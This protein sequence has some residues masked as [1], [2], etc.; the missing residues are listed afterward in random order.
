MIHKNNLFDNNL[1]YISNIKDGNLSYK[2]NKNDAILNREKLAK[3]L[4]IN[5]DNIIYMDQTHGDNIETVKNRDKKYFINTDAIITNIKNIALLVTVADCIPISIYDKVN[6]CI[7][8]VHSGRD[9]TYCKIIQKTIQKMVIEYGTILDNIIVYFGPSIGECCYEVGSDISN[10]FD[11][12]FKN[13][14]TDNNHLNLQEINKQIII[15]MG[16]KPK[17]IVISNICTSC[18]NKEYFSYRKNRDSSRFGII[19]MLR[20]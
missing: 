8:V 19:F 16:I 1:F 6:H 13:S 15:K 9:G 12:K 20:D 18:N 10:T 5:F 2:Y 17:N 14:K 7:G 3:K 11:N 4:D